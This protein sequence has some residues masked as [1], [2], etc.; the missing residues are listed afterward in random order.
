MTK[1]EWSHTDYAT[2]EIRTEGLVPGGQIGSL[3]SVLVVNGE[4]SRALAI[5]GDLPKFLHDVAAAVDTRTPE[6]VAEKVL[7]AHAIRPDWVRTGAQVAELL[8]EAVRE[9]RGVSA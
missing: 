3:G 8:A 9:A 1:F 2:V 7:E 4:Q 6:Q 5:T